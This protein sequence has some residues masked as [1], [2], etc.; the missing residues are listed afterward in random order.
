MTSIVTWAGIDSRGPA[1]VYIASDSRI[2]WGASH[3]WDHGRKTFAS[4]AASYVFGYSGEVLFPSM[5]LPIVLEQLAA[6]V[7]RASSRSP[8]GE[9]GSQIRQ[10][11]LTY[12]EQQRRDFSIVVACRHGVG[13]AARFFVAVMT[14]KASDGTWETREVPMPTNS[15]SL[16]VDG[17]GASEIR[18]AEGL[19]QA[20]DH[21]NTSRAVFSAF[22]E[23]LRLGGDPFTGGG[24]QLVGLHRIG[25]GKNFGVLFDRRRYFSGAVIDKKMAAASTSPWFNE[26]FERCDGERM[27]KLPKAQ[28]HA[29]R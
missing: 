26:L 24:P 4:A 27:V 8:F 23:S 14:H 22:C 20:S 15:A 9:I 11:W 3:K 1:S 19:W 12:P 7:L 5:A 17:S 2:S 16:L 28:R 25:N 13:M 6:D 10:L 18:A 21:A 29:P